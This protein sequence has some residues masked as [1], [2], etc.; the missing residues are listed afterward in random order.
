MNSCYALPVLKVSIKRFVLLTERI[1]A[2][3]HWGCC[4]DTKMIMWNQVITDSRTSVTP[5]S[6]SLFISWHTIEAPERNVLLMIIQMTGISSSVQ[7]PKTVTV[8]C[9]ENGKGLATHG[10]RAERARRARSVKDTWL[11]SKKN[12]FF[13]KSHQLRSVMPFPQRQKTYIRVC[14]ST[15]L[16]WIYWTCTEI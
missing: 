9:S 10:G 16:F 13:A 3:G 14:V 5:L 12:V 1:L 15:R 7:Q 8:G 11:E 6:C 2:W 4:C